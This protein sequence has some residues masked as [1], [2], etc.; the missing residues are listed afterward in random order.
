MAKKTDLMGLG[1]PVFLARRLGMEP[2]QVTAAGA[3]RASA[4]NLPGD[5][6]LACV[7]GTN[8][9]VGLEL[10]AVGGDT[11]ALL[12]DP[13]IVQALYATASVYPGSGATISVLG[14]S[15]GTATGV[16]V[17]MNTATV[18][19]PVTA[20]QWIGVKGA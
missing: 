2:L 6:Y 17:E 18:F 8:G 4:T 10:P 20:T 15:Y 7:I 11:G 19:Y 5:P 12:G 9:G 3:T 13:Y 14:A 1:M 16:T